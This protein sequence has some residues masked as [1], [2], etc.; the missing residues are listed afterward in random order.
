MKYELKDYIKEGTVVLS[1][2]EAERASAVIV[3]DDGVAIVG[4]NTSFGVFV[5][6]TGVTLQGS[7]L[8][9]SS[10]KDIRKGKYTENPKSTKLFS[11]TETVSMEGDAK[12]KLSEA[13]GKLGVNIGSMTQSG[14]VPLMTDIQSSPI[15][16]SHGMLFKHVHRIEPAYLYR[17]PG[18][19]KMLSGL[20]SK[21]SE[22]LSL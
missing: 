17:V 9:T 11:Y 3:N 20:L 21:F 10:G 14:I 8:I 22:F 7:V 18:Y 15:P 1:N 2:S 12:E 6:R 16:H 5:D 13:A 19:V 4:N